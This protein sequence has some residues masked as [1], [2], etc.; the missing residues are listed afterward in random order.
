MYKKLLAGV[1]V[2]IVMSVLGRLMQEDCLEFEDTTV[3]ARPSRPMLNKLSGVCMC[4]CVCAELTKAQH[5]QS[6]QRQ[7]V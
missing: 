4:V 6:E 3:S 5:T 7:L 2:Q 1:L